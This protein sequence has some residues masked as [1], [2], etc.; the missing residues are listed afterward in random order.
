MKAHPR[1]E[2]VHIVFRNGL[3]LEYKTYVGKGSVSYGIFMKTYK[4]MN[5]AIFTISNSP[6]RQHMVA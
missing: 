2:S 6:V 5:I 3:Y 4:G 1:S